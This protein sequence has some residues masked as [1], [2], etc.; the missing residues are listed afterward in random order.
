MHGLTVDALAD[1]T[2]EVRRR[3]LE[4]VGEWDY[5]TSLFTPPLHTSNDE[6]KIGAL[7]CPSAGGGTNIPGGTVADPEAG[8]IF[9]ASVKTCSS[10]TLVPGEQR[11]QELTGQSVSNPGQWTHAPAGV[12]SIDGIP[13]YKPPYVRI[14]AIDMITGEHLWWFRV[15]DSPDRF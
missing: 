9:T 6:G 12:G 1:F 8:I 15:G 7:F 10:F 13:F 4:V 11:D 5:G 2:P 14:T 3:A